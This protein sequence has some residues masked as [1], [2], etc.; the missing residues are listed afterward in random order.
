MAFLNALVRAVPV[1]LLASVAV[2]QDRQ[3]GGVGLTMF[4]DT[5]Y[6]GEALTLRN[7]NPNLNTVGMYQ[8]ASSLQIASGEQWEICDQPNYGGACL[9]VSG[10]ESDLRRRNWNDRVASARRVGGRGGRRGGGGG[11]IFPPGNQTG[12]ELY[13]N[14]R[15]Y[16]E[17]QMFTSA[18]S[19]FDQIGFNDRAMSLVVPQGEVWEVCVDS[20]FRNCRSF[21]GS[22]MDLGELG[23][24]RNI[25][26]VRPIRQGRG[27][28]GEGNT[29]ARLIL[30]DNT[31]FS[32]SSRTIDRDAPA[33][34]AFGNRA[35]SLQVMGGTWE[36]CDR[37]KFAGRCITVTG[38]M[39]D[40][41]PVG[42]SNQIQSVRLRSR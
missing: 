14:A 40:L 31:G 10:N 20:N 35:E 5:N 36:I 7:D 6:R 23:L 21:S 12:L 33:I 38:D 13:A 16:G 29:G 9:V 11:G 34:F 8:L 37:P 1:V 3:V 41:G 28:S 42:F 15:F 19:N 22:V 26:S 4:A 27:G 32:G 17:R 30:F 18:V 2:A 24:A 39:Q 25:S